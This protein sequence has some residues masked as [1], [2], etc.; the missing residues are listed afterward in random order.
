M[1]ELGGGGGAFAVPCTNPRGCTKRGII[2][3]YGYNIYIRHDILYSSFV[4]ILGI[5]II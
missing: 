1:D 3:A 5:L 4:H 2:C